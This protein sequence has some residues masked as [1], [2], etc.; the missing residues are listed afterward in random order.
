MLSDAPTH[1]ERHNCHEDSTKFVC[2]LTHSDPLGIYP[3]YNSRLN[4][5]TD[6][7]WWLYPNKLIIL[8]TDFANCY[9]RD[10][11]ISCRVLV[12]INNVLYCNGRINTFQRIALNNLNCAQ[13]EILKAFGYVQING[14]RNT[15]RF[16]RVMKLPTCTAKNKVNY[17]SKEQIDRIKTNI[18]KN[19]F[20]STTI[21][22]DSFILKS[23]ISHPP[24]NNPIQNELYIWSYAQL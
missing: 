23:T 9:M 12:L 21:I 1:R 10:T 24:R 8:N 5:T 17:L 11:E 15:W 22:S 19:L 18:G 2:T 20:E 7:L 3:K 14:I 13:L 16:F 4:G 6:Y